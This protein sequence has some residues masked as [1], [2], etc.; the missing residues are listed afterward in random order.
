MFPEWKGKYRARTIYSD[1]GGSSYKRPLQYQEFD[2][3]SLR[4]FSKEDLMKKQQEQ[5]Q[6]KQDNTRVNQPLRKFPKFR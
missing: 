4:N 3:S 2:H 1:A 6:I 5:I